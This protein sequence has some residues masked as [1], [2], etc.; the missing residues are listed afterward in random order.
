MTRV[1][2]TNVELMGHRCRGHCRPG[3][4]AGSGSETQVPSQCETEVPKSHSTLGQPNVEQM[5]NSRSRLF[6]N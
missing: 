3:A 2:S 1:G 6:Q 4:E 5:W